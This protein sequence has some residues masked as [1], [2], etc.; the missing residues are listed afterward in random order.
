MSFLLIFASFRRHCPLPPVEKK[1]MASSDRL[2]MLLNQLQSMETALTDFMMESVLRLQTLTEAR[3]FLLIENSSDRKRRYCGS[4][5]LVDLFERGALS[6][7]T[8]DMTV[9]L[10]TSVASHVLIDRPSRKRPNGV[11]SLSNDSMDNHLSP[12]LHIG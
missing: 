11:S 8:T 1:S 7:D 4:T 9:E 12:A 6:Q 2:F 5:E 3:V 10:N